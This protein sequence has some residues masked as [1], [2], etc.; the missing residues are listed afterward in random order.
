VARPV[1]I[2]IGPVITAVE[3]PKLILGTN[4]SLRLFGQELHD[5]DG[6][7]AFPGMDLRV[8]SPSVSADGSLLEILLTIPDDAE[9]NRRKLRLVDG[10]NAVPFAAPMQ[11]IIDIDDGPPTISSI[12][13]IGATAGELITLVIRGARLDDVYRVFAEPPDGLAFSVLPSPAPDGSDV[14]VKI[15]IAADAEP[16]SRTIRVETPGGVSDETQRA[17]NRFTIY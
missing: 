13:P 8:A 1:G 7:A 4:R 11:A 17:A 12:D 14:A 6:V 2:A 5:V 16:G 10:S 3:V 15:H 9:P